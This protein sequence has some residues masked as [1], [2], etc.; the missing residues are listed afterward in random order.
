[1]DSFNITDVLKS[2]VLFARKRGVFLGDE[3]LP[4][5]LPGSNYFPALK[6]NCDYLRINSVQ[7]IIKPESSQVEFLKLLKVEMK[8]ICPYMTIDDL[9]SSLSKLIPGMEATMFQFKTFNTVWLSF[10]SARES[11]ATSLATLMPS[12]YVARRMELLLKNTKN[13]KKPPEIPPYDYL[14]DAL[15]FT[16]RKS[17]TSNRKCR[18]Q[19]HRNI[20]DEDEPPPQR[21]RRG[22]KNSKSTV[23]DFVDFVVS[24]NAIPTTL[25]SR[26]SNLTPLGVSNCISP[27][28]TDILN[29]PQ[30]PSSKIATFISSVSKELGVEVDPCH[31]DG[32]ISTLTTL[33]SIQQDEYVLTAGEAKLQRRERWSKPPN[34]G[35]TPLD[36]VTRGCKEIIFSEPATGKNDNNYITKLRTCLAGLIAPLLNTKALLQ[37]RKVDQKEKGPYRKSM[38]DYSARKMKEKENI[39][40]LEHQK[41]KFVNFVVE[42]IIVQ[43]SSCNRTTVTQRALGLS[44]LLNGVS[45]EVFDNLS[46]LGLTCCRTTAKGMGVELLYHY[47][48]IV[49]PTIRKFA[50]NKILRISHDNQALISRDNAPKRGKGVTKCIPTTMFQILFPGECGENVNIHQTKL[51]DGFLVPL[52]DPVKTKSLM[53]K[54]VTIFNDESNNPCRYLNQV[55]PAFADDCK[56][57]TAPFPSLRDTLPLKSGLYHY[58]SYTNFRDKVLVTVA[59]LLRLLDFTPLIL[60]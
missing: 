6:N 15:S 33:L 28:P 56:T 35:A 47:D 53:R 55:W 50:K 1:M 17:A 31:I 2:A 40:K 4:L 10:G 9:S 43:R 8:P 22:D 23:E 51:D 46:S 44:N 29:P 12:H 52:Y 54:Y 11:Q 5:V 34:E 30:L 59:E 49:I 24:P 25:G 39:E 27:I 20:D 42:Y 26:F 13:K 32:L 19:S 21:P 45:R 48:N 57:S 60:R 38:N 37:R 16:L 36:E 41:D 18:L 7:F 58:G 14:L 3:W